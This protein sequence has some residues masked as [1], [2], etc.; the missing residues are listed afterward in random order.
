MAS[1]KSPEARP[2]YRRVSA[3]EIAGAIRAK[4]CEVGGRTLDLL[5]VDVD[6]GEVRLSAEVPSSAEREI[7]VRVVRDELGFDAGRPHERSP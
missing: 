3:G 5:D 4:L 2:E 6:G 1:R 7:A